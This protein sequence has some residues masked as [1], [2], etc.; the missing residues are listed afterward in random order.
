MFLYRFGGGLGM[1]VGKNEAGVVM[2][3]SVIKSKL[4]PDI[5]MPRAVLL[6]NAM[7]NETAISVMR[8]MTDA[9]GRSPFSYNLVVSDNQTIVASQNTPFE[10]RITQVKKMIVQSNQYDYVDWIKHLKKPS[11]SKKRQLYAEELLQKL[12]YRYGYVTDEDLLEIL[13]DEPVICRNAVG[14]GIGTTVLFLTRQSFG[15][16]NPLA[17]PIGKIPF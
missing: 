11:Y 5:M 12:L 9:K 10:S 15:H 2:T 7:K 16:G 8:E 13:R 14:D 4:K 17:K 1:A 3:V 6:R